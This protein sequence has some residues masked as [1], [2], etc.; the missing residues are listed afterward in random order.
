MSQRIAHIHAV[1][2]RLGR[3][4]AAELSFE[5][6]GSPR[7]TKSLWPS[8]RSPGRP[9]QAVQ[10]SSSSSRTTLSSWA[11]LAAALGGLRSC[12]GGPT[13]SRCCQ[14]RQAPPKQQQ[15]GP[16]FDS[17]C[18]DAHC[19]CRIGS[20]GVALMFGLSPGPRQHRNTA[21]RRR[22]A[23]DPT[24]TTTT[25]TRRRAQPRPDDDEDPRPRSAMPAA[26]WLST[27]TGED[28]GED[29]RRQ[30]RRRAADDGD[31][32]TMTTGDR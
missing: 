30:Q 16:K 14:V 3:A 8:T 27:S 1:Q 19:R 12:G 2:L 10:D 13:K 28:R 5:G 21:N 25:T 20:A 9:G 32:Q 26:G 23:Q 31:D 24:T 11:R 6:G 18:S 29:Q 4:C 15:P 17:R 22:G 7:S